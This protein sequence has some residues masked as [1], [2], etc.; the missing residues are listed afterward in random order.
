[1]NIDWKN[2]NRVLVVRLRSIGDTV[3]ATPSLVALR[4]FLPAAQIDILLEDWVAPVLQGFDSVDD[5]ITVS[6]AEKKSRFETA[7]SLRQNKYDAAFNLHGGTT[8][9][10]FVRASGARAR[11]GYHNYQYNFLYTHR[12]PDS[13]EFWQQEHVQSAEHQLAL[14]GSVGIPVADK[15]KSRLAVTESARNSIENKILAK[16]KIQNPKSRR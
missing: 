9:T 3:L 6:R 10:F 16:S 7:L 2:T 4:R 1:M 8:A 5:V 12:A 14:L 13:T 15:P 11:I